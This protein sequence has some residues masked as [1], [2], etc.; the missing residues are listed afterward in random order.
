MQTTPSRPNLLSPYRDRRSAPRIDVTDRLRATVASSE[1]PIRVRNIS[2]GGCLL[3]SEEPLPVGALQQFRFETLDGTVS[4]TVTARVI[5]SRCRTIRP[6]QVFVTGVRFVAPR[7]ADVSA[8]FD[9]LM[10]AVTSV[11]SFA[12]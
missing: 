1:M 5:H 12:Q 10:D 2:F 7:M 11:L 6:R 8:E 4:V 9:R 3:E